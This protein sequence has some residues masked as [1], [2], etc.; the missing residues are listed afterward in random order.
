M[1]GNRT[2]LSNA[3]AGLSCTIDW[4]S[5]SIHRLALALVGVS[6][7][8]GCG[9]STE[10]TG[11]PLPGRGTEVP[12]TRS[13]VPAAKERHA[14]S[15]Q[16][17]N[18]ARARPE[19]RP[20]VA[21]RRAP[22]DTRVLMYLGGPSLEGWQ[23]RLGPGSS[24]RAAAEHSTFP[25]TAVVRE[26][27]APLYRGSR[28][29]IAGWARRGNRLP[30]RQASGSRCESRAPYEVPGAAFVCARDG[31]E[32]H[33][34]QPPAPARDMDLTGPLPFTYGRVTTEPAPRMSRL[35]LPD[36]LAALDDAAIHGGTVSGLVA[37]WMVGDYFVAIASVER[38]GDREFYRTAAGNYVRVEDI[39][40]LPV[41][42]MHGEHLSEGELPIAFVLEDTP[43]QCELD[44]VLQPCGSAEKHARF[45][46]R[47][48][49][50]RDGQVFVR[51]PGGITLPA[52]AVRVVERIAP[53]EDI[54]ASARWVHIDLSRQALVAYEGEQ[55][56]F[57]TLVSSGRE[58]YHTP[59]GLYRVQRKYLTKSMAGKD[60]ENGRRYQVQE[61]PWTMYYDRNF[62]VHGAYWHNR[63]G[64]TK[65]HG[66]TN[67]PPVDA[68]WLY[69]WSSPTLPRGWHAMNDVEGTW[70]Y[71]SGE[72]PSDGI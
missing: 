32:I 66:C 17:P 38:V 55:P 50:D 71:F 68:R 57:V 25:L 22:V 19:R 15:V 16:P 34:G 27:V 10:T 65:S 2:T 29:I 23:P 43:A 70:F 11:I 14:R 56:V 64:K 72:S 37:R 36:E 63:F 44:G 28:R 20:P 30:A 39:T 42:P 59:D 8:I 5:A 69:H 62:A 49:L 51:G 35:P 45:P 6:T 24:R 40:I 21:D 33:A 4:M 61:V 18:L 41:P 67:V 9:A 52:D 1:T 31:F 13:E 54:P 26:Q 48:T 53:P 47:G 60:I 3:T 58:G 12:R 7:L 46:V